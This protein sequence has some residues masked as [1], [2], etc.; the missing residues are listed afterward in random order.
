MVF[1]L[2]GLTAPVDSNDES[3]ILSVIRSDIIWRNKFDRSN[4][5]RKLGS[6][7][8]AKVD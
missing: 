2:L 5:M 4:Q 3:L 8:F 7:W 6:G 1:H